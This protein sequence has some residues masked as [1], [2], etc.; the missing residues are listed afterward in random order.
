MEDARHQT[1]R[2]LDQINRQITRRM[3]ALIPL[4]QPKRTGH[5]RGK[6]PDPGAFLARKLGRLDLAIATLR[7]RHHLHPG[8]AA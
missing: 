5:R 3:T 8:S 7:E 6:P 2:Q 1:R 4:L